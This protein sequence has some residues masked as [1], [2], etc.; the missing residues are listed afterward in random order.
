[1]QGLHFMVI[2]AQKCGTT[3]LHELL[4]DHPNL[5]LPLNKEAPFFDSAPASF[6]QWQNFSR[7]FFGTTE[8]RLLGKCTPQYLASSDAA[9]RA[10]ALFPGMTIL[11]MLRP[12]IERTLS[13]YRMCLRRGQI[14]AS[15]EECTEKWLQPGALAKARRAAMTAQN[16]A[17]CCIA[18][19]EYGRQ[20][21]PWIDLFGEAQVHVHF[22]TDLEARPAETMRQIHSQI[23]VDADWRSSKT[24]QQFFK[25]GGHTRLSRLRALRRLPW[26]SKLADQ[27]IAHMPP[28]SAYRLQQWNET[29][30]GKP[31]ATPVSA[32]TMKRLQ[33][34]FSEDLE[35][36]KQQGFNPPWGRN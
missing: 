6:P 10:H 13:H 9:K 21:Q 24:G 8:N 16:E 14:G 29:N 28:R 5:A 7:Q 19:S 27:M 2:G 1:M 26:A 17:D 31:A 35:L 4:R 32:E 33:N 15:F 30:R 11:A 34:H 18:W 3:T 36:L 20:L 12:P 22:L 25:G 23:G